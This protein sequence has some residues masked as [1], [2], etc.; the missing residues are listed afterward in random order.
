MSSEKFRVIVFFLFLMALLIFGAVYRP[1]DASG[2]A[3]E[4]TVQSAAKR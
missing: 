1:V 3:V 4:N 2:H